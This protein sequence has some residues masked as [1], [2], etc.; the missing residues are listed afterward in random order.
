MFHHKS[1]DIRIVVHGDDFT[2]LASCK[3]LDWFRECIS[4]RFEVK[5]RGR[6]G[7]G[8]DEEHSIRILNRVLE[9][10]DEGLRYEAD[11]RHAE[12]IIQ[13]LGL[14]SDSKPVSSPSV[15]SSGDDLYGPKPGYA[16]LWTTATHHI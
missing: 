8:R 16:R 15:A 12:I 14:R 1:R 2:V 7:P 4:S 13:Q 10:T 6:L 11:Q 5:F 3:E 9:W